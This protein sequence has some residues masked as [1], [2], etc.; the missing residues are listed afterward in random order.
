MN[1][2]INIRKNRIRKL[3]EE[4]DQLFSIIDLLTYAEQVIILES[5]T[6]MTH[7]IDDEKNAIKGL[8][9]NENNQI[10]F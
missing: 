4:R 1:I 8:L 10:N 2:E 7:S 5:I 3:R 9:K 6:E